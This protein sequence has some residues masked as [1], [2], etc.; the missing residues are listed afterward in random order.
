VRVNDR[1]EWLFGCAVKWLHPSCQD[2]IYY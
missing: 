2:C 1:K